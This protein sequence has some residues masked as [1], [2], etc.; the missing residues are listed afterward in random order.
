MVTHRCEMLPARAEDSIASSYR[1][2]CRSP[3]NQAVWCDR[4]QHW[5]WERWCSD[6]FNPAKTIGGVNEPRTALKSVLGLLMLSLSCRDDHHILLM[7]S[8]QPWHSVW[9]TE[10]NP[11]KTRL[12]HIPLSIQYLTKFKKKLFNK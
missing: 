9:N 2:A 5:N 7:L 3:N 10:I 4:C 11:F 12:K 1:S 6:A 8:L